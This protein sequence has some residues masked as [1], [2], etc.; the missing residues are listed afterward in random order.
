M[1]FILDIPGALPISFRAVYSIELCHNVQN[2]SVLNYHGQ[3]ATE[4]LLL[5]FRMH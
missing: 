1:Q 4:Y 3:N 2:L 5:H